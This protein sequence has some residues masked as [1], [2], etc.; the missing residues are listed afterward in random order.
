[1]RRRLETYFY[2][3]AYLSHVEVVIIFYLPPSRACVLRRKKTTIISIAQS[4]YRALSRQHARKTLDSF[5]P[6]GG[7]LIS[8]RLDDEPRVPRAAGNA[9]CS[10]P[11]P[12]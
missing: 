8:Q 3:Y 1:M 12:T 4:V 11:D 9:L 10:L 5:A 2:F 7:A 6:I